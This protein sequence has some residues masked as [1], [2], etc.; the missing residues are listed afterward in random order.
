MW[1]LRFLTHPQY[2]CLSRGTLN[3]WQLRESRWNSESKNLMESEG[4]VGRRKKGGDGLASKVNWEIKKLTFV[5]FCIYFGLD[6]FHLWVSPFFLLS[7]SPNTVI[8]YFQVILCLCFNIDCEQSLYFLQLVSHVRERWALSGT[9]ET[10]SFSQGRVHSLAF[11]R[12]TTKK[13]R[14]L[15]V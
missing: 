7:H 3:R 8:G 12:R 13:E 6:V 14:L 5:I 1:I 15:V 9:R 11:V 4:S 10:R 2:C